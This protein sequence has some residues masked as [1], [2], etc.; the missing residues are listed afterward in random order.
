MRR[1]Q[2]DSELLDRRPLIRFAIAE[3]KRRKQTGRKQT[4]A[5]KFKKNFDILA[6]H[7][8]RLFRSDVYRPPSPDPNPPRNAQELIARKKP[9]GC[10]WYES[11]DVVNF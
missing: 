10:G 9:I 4:V 7:M 1:S 11:Q 3:D 8:R 6:R 2:S 5:A